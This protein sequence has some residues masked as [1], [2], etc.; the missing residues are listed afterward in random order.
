MS[1]GSVWSYLED[2]GVAEVALLRGEGVEGSAELALLG[3]RGG[4]GRAEGDEVGGL[5]RGGGGGADWSGGGRGRAFGVGGLRGGVGS[6]DGRLGCVR[7]F[8]PR[9][10]RGGVACRYWGSFEAYSLRQS[11]YV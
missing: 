7:A 5:L 3:R 2:R 11:C 6:V 4:F 9:T 8:P 1:G 10:L